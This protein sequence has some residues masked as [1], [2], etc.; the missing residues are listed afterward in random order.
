[1]HQLK[2][3]K[4]GKQSREVSEKTKE[5]ILKAALKVFAREGFYNTKLREIADLTDTTHSLIRHHFGTKFDLYK[6]AAD[7]GLNIHEERLRRVTKL[8]KSSNPVELFKDFIASYVST[9]AK[10]PEVSKIIM[11]NNNTTSPLFDYLMERK[12]QLNVI[13]EPVF[14]E[15]QKSGYFEDFDHDSFFV[16][17]HALVE[18]PIAMMD[19]ANE[20]LGQNLLSRKGIAMHT[21][22]VLSFLFP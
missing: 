16:Y 2:K 14:R 21:E 12:K 8:N 10:N 18:T 9:V 1:M 19:M 22:H 6:A 3:R 17:L 5:T 13:V 11:H 15:V 4:L 7:Y 20:L